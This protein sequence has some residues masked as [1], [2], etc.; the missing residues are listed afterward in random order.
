MS[1]FSKE[2]LKLWRGGERHRWAGNRKSHTGSRTGHVTADHQHYFRY[3]FLDVVVQ[4]YFVQQCCTNVF[5]VLF[6]APPLTLDAAQTDAA[7]ASLR[8]PPPLILVHTFRFCAVMTCRGRQ[9]S[10]RFGIVCW[11]AV[12]APPSVPSVSMTTSESR[13]SLDSSFLSLN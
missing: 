3:C 7:S 1:I 6:L 10:S 2:F 4:L 11:E 8:A 9:A 13:F 12:R 5:L